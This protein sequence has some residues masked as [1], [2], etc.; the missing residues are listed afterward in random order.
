MIAQWTFFWA[1]V[2]RR[3]KNSH[4]VMQS[5]PELFFLPDTQRDDAARYTQTLT[6]ARK[7]NTS[8]KPAT[9]QHTQRQ[10]SDKPATNASDKP[11][12]HT[13]RQASDKPATHKS[14]R[15]ASH[16]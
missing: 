13:Q 12:K 11:A 14:Q 1:Q 2:D 3:V 10:A 6:T 9:S 8:H 15:Q 7:E 16:A 4:S 5:K